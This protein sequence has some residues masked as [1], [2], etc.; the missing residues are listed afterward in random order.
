MI[1]LV[2]DDADQRLALKMALELAGYRVREAAH[3]GE[4]LRLQ[5]ER[6][7]SFLI[8]DIF[9]PEADGFETIEAFRREFPRTRIIAVSGG[10]RRAKR[11]YLEA[12]TLLGV[13]A[14]LHKPFEIEQ[15]L[16]TL[17]NLGDHAKR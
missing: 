8:T 1:I 12:A 7:A 5:R 11:D 16:D 14:A 4:A 9:M 13:D 17:R 6:S 2:D 3:G 10:G 15:L